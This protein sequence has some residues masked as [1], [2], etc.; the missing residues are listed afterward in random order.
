M[1]DDGIDRARTVNEEYLRVLASTLGDLTVVQRT[2]LSPSNRQESLVVDLRGDHVP[3]AITEVRLEIRSY[4]DGTFHVTYGEHYLGDR[5]QCRWDRHDQ[6][7]SSHDHFHPLPDASTDD[8][9]NRRYP[10]TLDDTIAEVVLPWV[11]DRIGTLWE[12]L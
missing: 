3:P 10:E 7:H 2:T 8:A 11:D 12:K 6:P 5:R 4:T 1:V 9:E